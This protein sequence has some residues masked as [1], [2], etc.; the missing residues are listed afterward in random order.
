M[1]N[2]P[3]LVYVNYNVVFYRELSTVLQLCATIQIHLP[4]FCYHQALPIAAN[5]RMCLIHLE[6][7]TKPVAACAIPI[8]SGMRI[9][10]ES[11]LVRQVRENV[12][13]FLL[14]NHPLDCPICD[15]GGECDLQDQA[16]VFG[17]DRGR[18]YEKKRA[19]KDNLSLGIVIKTFMTRC[20][21]CTRCVRFTQDLLGTN[22]LGVLGRGNSMRITTFVNKPIFSYLSGNIA[23]ICPVGALTSK[24]Y[25]FTARPWELTPHL[26][27]DFFDAVGGNLR[28]DTRGVEIMRVLPYPN[29]LVNDEWA[30]DKARLAYDGFTRQRLKRP[31]LCRAVKRPFLPIFRPNTIQ[32]FFILDKKLTD[33]LVTLFINKTLCSLNYFHKICVS[34]I[35]DAESVVSITLLSK[36]FSYST[37]PA[38]YDI[39]NNNLTNNLTCFYIRLFFSPLSALQLPTYNYV[40]FVSFDGNREAPLFY[41][42]LVKADFRRKYKLLQFSTKVNSFSSAFIEQTPSFTPHSFIKQIAKM[43]QIYL[44]LGQACFSRADFKPML[45]YLNYSDFKCS[46]FPAVSSVPSLM[47]FS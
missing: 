45:Y 18:Y 40:G 12:L 24:P 46:V 32:A 33:M 28:M 43:E 35:L 42:K 6:D 19:V 11:T 2:R 26:T 36:L 3:N 13:E 17:S 1:Y 10:T 8:N 16:M 7:A 21:H 47:E 31:L 4:R 9:I 23:D 5:C 41:L 37:Q 20:I 39:F 27:I 25:A 22:D 30:T 15:Q 38:I 34:P 29:Q 14:I 44:L